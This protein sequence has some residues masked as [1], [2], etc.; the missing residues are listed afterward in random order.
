MTVPGPSE[1]SHPPAH[2]GFSTHT[3][4]L[5]W[6]LAVAYLLVIAYASL[7]PFRGW[8]VPPAEV[9]YFL[10]APWAR[11][12]I[13]Q[14]VAVNVGAYVPLGF[15]LSMG[16]GAR[17]GP[18]R[19]AFAATIA[20]GLLSLAMEA[21]QAFLP[22]RIAS[23]LDLLANSVG[24]LLGAMAAPLFAPSRILGGTLHAARRRL[25]LDGMTADAGL[26]LA[27]LWLATQF[28]PTA[29][30]F[31]TGSLRA[32]LD[33]PDLLI[34]TPGLALASEAAVVLF[35]LLGV[36]LMLSALMHAGT[37]ALPV[38]ATVIGMALVIKIFT[39]AALVQAA[40]PLAWLTPG[41][42]A[43]LAA[44]GALLYG[45]ARLPRRAQLAIAAA[46]I[47]VAT[48][49]INL[50]P[51]NPYQ[52]VPPRLLAGRPSHF[53]SFSGIVRALSELWPLLATGFLLYALL[54]RRQ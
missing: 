18:A 25:F 31:G 11:F 15:L 4:R 29:R 27:A 48:V 54:A 49:A 3:V 36:G 34:H 53:F 9:L 13:L 23:N 44:G 52:S 10:N 20:A 30:L 1:S 8:R 21:A 51:D 37:R 14:D 41:V 12:I 24:A 19:G 6:I 17:F 2:A 42:L 33:L 26:V 46:C 50:A 22:S 32:T 39:A 45:A 16:L 38:I 40:A 28:H 5:A 47:V 43:G 35:N 7:Q